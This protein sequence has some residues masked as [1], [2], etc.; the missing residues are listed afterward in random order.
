MIAGEMKHMS[1][2]LHS[3]NKTIIILHQTTNSGPLLWSETPDFLG[4]GAKK[5]NLKVDFN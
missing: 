2:F 1:F 4:G 5:V 3:N